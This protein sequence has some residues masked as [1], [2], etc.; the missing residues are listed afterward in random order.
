MVEQRI[1]VVVGLKLFR[2]YI[3]DMDGRLACNVVKFPDD[4]NILIAIAA[5]HD[6]PHFGGKIGR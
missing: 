6:Y 1:V 2:I 5:K 3:S 4:T